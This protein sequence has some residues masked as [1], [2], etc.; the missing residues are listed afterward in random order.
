MSE[1][2]ILEGLVEHILLELLAAQNASN[3][4]SA[5][6]AERYLNPES[7]KDVPNLEFFPVPNSSIKAFDFNLKF[8]L[9]DIGIVLT[10][11]VIKKINELIERIWDMLLQ[12]LTDQGTILE[13]RRD[14]L[15]QE[16]PILDFA[17]IKDKAIDKPAKQ[18]S[19]ASFLEEEIIKTLVAQL[20]RRTR[21]R[22]VE[23]SKAIIPLDIRRQLNE[24]LFQ[25]KQQQE[26]PLP[27]VKAVFD[28][29][30]LNQASGEIICEINVHVEM[31]NFDS[32]Y[33][34]NISNDKNNPPQTRLLTLR[35]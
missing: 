28:L 20:P 29:G 35:N 27:D 32:A 22:K 21:R 8:A 13:R 33:Y 18:E 10:A 24:I 34:N 7:A 3:E 12:N 2:S 30:Q 11:E 14:S 16:K 15:L 17:A 23:I 25:S 5:Q 1:N 9:K 6:L 26:I 19:I 4:A 31:R